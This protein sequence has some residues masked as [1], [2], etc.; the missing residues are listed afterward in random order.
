M[1]RPKIPKLF[2]VAPSSHKSLN[3]PRGTSKQNGEKPLLNLGNM[4]SVVN[5]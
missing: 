1:E 2:H 3:T 4:V 5:E